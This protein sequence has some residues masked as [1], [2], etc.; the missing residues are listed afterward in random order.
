M[1]AL[2]DQFGR[3]LRQLRVERNMTQE[4][5]AEALNKTPE[6]I[7]NIERGIN[8]P[9]FETLEKLET[10]LDLPISELFNWKDNALNS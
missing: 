6:F 9:S 10:A 5:L 8:A 7:S 4:T 3:H 2:R 1:G